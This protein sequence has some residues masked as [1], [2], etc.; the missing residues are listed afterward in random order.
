M[1]H[2]MYRLAPDTKNGLAGDGPCK[3]TL[4]VNWRALNRIMSCSP[5]ISH[6]LRLF[7]P[8]P[9][10]QVY[11][12]QVGRRPAYNTI[13]SKSFKNHSIYIFFSLL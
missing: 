4:L 5:L 13:F 8:Q 1:L 6:C 3:H 10:S 11:P 2:V 12:G 7:Q 9:A